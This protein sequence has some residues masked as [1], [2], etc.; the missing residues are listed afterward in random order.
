MPPLRR[1]PAPAAM[2]LQSA[3]A[4]A[5]DA[6]HG[7]PPVQSRGADVPRPPPARPDGERAALQAAAPAA[8]GAL[9]RAAGAGAMALRAAPRWRSALPSVRRWHAET[10]AAAAPGDES[11]A[12]AGLA[13]IMAL[14]L[15]VTTLVAVQ[16]WWALV[17]AL[18]ALALGHWC[19]GARGSQAVP[20]ARWL[21]TIALVVTYTWL[22]LYTIGTLVLALHGR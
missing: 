13:A 10:I 22:A 4:S 8:R 19:L 11:E 9:E 3:G 5:P 18:P 17:A 21:A 7:G 20:E 6:R 14:V 15:A 16:H 1:G 2:R 12:R